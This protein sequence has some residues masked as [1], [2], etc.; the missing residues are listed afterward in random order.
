METLD[1]A[2]I[3]LDARNQRVD[4]RLREAL[5]SESLPRDLLICGPAG[6]GKTYGILSVL[7]CLAADYPGLRI[8]ICRATRTALTESVLVTLEQE[9][10]PADDCE[11]LAAGCT[12]RTRHSYVYP[13]GSEIVIGGLDKPGKVLSQAWDLVYI[14]EAIETTEEMWETLQSRLS[15]PGRPTW[16]GYLIG[17]TNPGDPSHWLKRRAEAGSTVLWDTTHRANPRLYGRHG[18]TAEGLVLEASLNRLTGSRRKRL[19]DG[20]WAAGEGA[21]FDGFDTST[22]VSELAEFDPR[23]PV[24]LAVDS[25]PHSGAVWLQFRPPGVVVF[26]DYY[27]FNRGAL[28]VAADLLARSAGFPESRLDFVSTDP[29][30]RAST[31]I[32]PTVIEEYARAGLKTH[33]WPIR[34]VLDSLALVESFVSVD[35]P[36]ML[37]HPRCKALIDAFANYKRAK[38]Q[39]QWIEKPEDPQ[40]P[41]E[42]LIDAL[43]GGLCDHW[44]EGRR[45]PPKLRRFKAGRV[46]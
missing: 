44:P 6:T 32:G 19:R 25:G 40:H 15:R 29:A 43:R 30:G 21:W 5:E 17:D 16:L 11:D 20:L 41:Y 28:G 33:S 9:I 7:H 37:V 38:R 10:L 24:H 34:T 14:N 42:E 39:Q 18:L 46:F 3:Y 12:R 35:P 26:S 36:E 4:Q 13:T 31:A 8:L 22:H 2:S 1:H 27:S 23:F 45:E